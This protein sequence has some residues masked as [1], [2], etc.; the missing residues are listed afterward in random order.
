MCENTRV[1]RNVPLKNYT[2]FRIGGNAERLL[3]TDDW[4]TLMQEQD[5]ALVIGCGSNLLVGDGG[6]KGTVIRFCSNACEPRILSQSEKDTVVYISGAAKLSLLSRYAADSGLS[7]LEWAA[8]IPGTVGGAVKMNA[9]AHGSDVKSR[10]VYADV[11]DKKRL[12]RLNAE[13]LKLGYR[14]SGFDG[15][16]VG[17]AFRLSRSGVQA[18]QKETERLGRLRDKAQP[19]GSSAGS[20]YKAADGVPAYKYV[21]AAGLSGFRI[22]GAKVSEKHA[23]FIINEG[24]ATARDVL[25]LM[26][27]IESEVYCK[28]GVKLEREVRTVGEF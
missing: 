1:F 7:G 23:N 20:V 5:G 13:D 15:I 27:K 3:E 6:V 14:T 17:A 26:E 12:I 2:T 9:G 22:G 10:I 19:K 21:A 8:R 11:S 25:E 24:G 18:V 28:F 16:A 4:Q